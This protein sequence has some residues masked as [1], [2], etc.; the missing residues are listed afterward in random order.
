MLLGDMKIGVIDR[1]K[2]AVAE[3]VIWVNVVAQR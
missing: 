3:Q 2:G 1:P